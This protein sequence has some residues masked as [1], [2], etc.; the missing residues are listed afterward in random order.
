MERTGA[1]SCGHQNLAASTASEAGVVGASLQRELLDGVDAGNVKQRAIRA[2]V[3]DVRAVHRPVISR[4]ACAV[5]GDGRITV[6]SAKARLIAEQVHNA[7][8]Q[9]HQ[10]LK[11]AIDQLQLAHLRSRD[12][13]G[14]GAD[15]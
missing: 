14:L 6:N 9:R 3:V 10:L 8:L 13:S 4:S 2:A 1:R 11:V 7:W 5:D 12:G 15:A